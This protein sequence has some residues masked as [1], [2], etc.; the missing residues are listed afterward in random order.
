MTYPYEYSKKEIELIEAME[1]QDV[2]S[3]PST[4]PPLVYMWMAIQCFR[5]NRNDNMSISV[6]NCLLAM[7]KAH[8]FGSVKRLTPEFD[9]LIEL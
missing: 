1:F 6:R 8:L 5:E 2:A 9:K 7:E 3:S 4:P